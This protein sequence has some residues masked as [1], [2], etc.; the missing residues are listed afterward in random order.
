MSGDRVDRGAS[1]EMS[2]TPVTQTEQEA[3]RRPPSEPGAGRMGG[4]A[5]DSSDVDT[6]DDILDDGDA[7]S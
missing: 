6:D 3:S 4:R 2:D 1:E 7:P 5:S